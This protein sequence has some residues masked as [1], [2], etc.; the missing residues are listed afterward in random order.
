M[1][2]KRRGVVLSEPS[3]GGD[4]PFIEVCELLRDNFEIGVLKSV[5][6]CI[7]TL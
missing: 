6:Q 4:P 3:G 2:F 1:P 7:L 5:F